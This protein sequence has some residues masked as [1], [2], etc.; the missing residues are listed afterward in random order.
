MQLA[1]TELLKMWLAEREIQ[2]QSAHTLQAYARDVGDFL[3]FCQNKKLDL[4]DVE[5][6]DLR[7]FVAEKVEQQQLASSTLQRML[8]AIRQFMK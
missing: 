8:S 6:S 1:A 2:N 5:T 7:Q 3:A 4:N